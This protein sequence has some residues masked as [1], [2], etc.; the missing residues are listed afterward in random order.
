MHNEWMWL[1]SSK[2]LF[3]KESDG[4]DL[5]HGLR[6]ADPCTVILRPDRWRNWS[7]SWGFKELGL[8]VILI[9][10]WWVWFTPLHCS[11][12]HDSDPGTT[13]EGM[14]PGKDMCPTSPSQEISFLL[15]SWRAI[16]S[17]ACLLLSVNSPALEWLQC[18]A[19]FC[20]HCSLTTASGRR[21]LSGWLCTS[22][23]TWGVFGIPKWNF[24]WRTNP[25]WALLGQPLLIPG[26]S[27][28]LR[29]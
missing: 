16:K 23:P 2:T 6:C 7:P 8:V 19:T 11:P 20:P 17:L 28:L 22:S 13:V 12:S 3:V 1:C 18:V 15:S 9:P 24:T 10:G 5:V 29:F 14:V 26:G 25:V 21:I 27:E 4:L